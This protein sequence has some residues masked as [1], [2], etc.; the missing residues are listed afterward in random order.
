MILLTGGTGFVGRHLARQFVADGRRVRVLSRTPGRISFPDDVSL[1][2]GDLTDP[3]SLRSALS[4]VNT[5]V[6]AG[7]VLRDG[8]TPDSSAL[9]RVN[10]GGTEALARAARDLGVRH[11]IHISSGGVYG[12]GN[13]G[14]PHQEGDTPFPVT[15][16]ER[17]KLS[18]EQ[19]LVATLEG[20]RTRW[21]I[22]RPQGLYG[23][24]RPETVAFFRTVAQRAW[25]LHG[26]AHL[27]VHPTHIDDLTAA[28]RLVLDRDDLQHQVINIG[29]ARWLEY[30]ELISMTGARVGHVPYQ[31][32]APPWTGQIAA[33]ISRAWGAAVPPPAL[34]ARL[35]RVWVNRAVSIEKARR[36]LR[37]QP[38][39]LESGLDQTVAEL[40]RR[41]LL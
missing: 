32:C 21:T 35:A 26:P 7:A 18:A 39:T 8:S 9:G 24:D 23:P 16:Y 22:L 29:G 15:P 3:A 1:A 2:Q 40:R 41:E 38:L 14:S 17:S 30:R 13:T 25:W 11:F 19:A 12:D 20:S 34:L 10:V 5:V 28:V 4:D 27:V 33:V 31:L 36:L 6:H 37:F